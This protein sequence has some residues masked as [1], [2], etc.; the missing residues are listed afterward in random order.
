MGS[1]SDRQTVGMP[2]HFFAI[3]AGDLRAWWSGGV[4][5]RRSGR[6]RISRR[7]GT[8]LFTL[9]GAVEI[10]PADGIVTDGLL[11]PVW[12]GLT[13]FVQHLLMAFVFLYAWSVF[14]RQQGGRKDYERIHIGEQVELLSLV[15][16][17]ARDSNGDPKVHAHVLLP[18]P[19]LARSDE[20]YLS[21]PASCIGLLDSAGG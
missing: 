14:V 10:I 4:A 12:P 8:G 9:V 13:L 15:G 5:T 19:S 1:S 2:A 18:F 17:I 20:T 16:D 11:L 21:P 3:S 6:T 7:V